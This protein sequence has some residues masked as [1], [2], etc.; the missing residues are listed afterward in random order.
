MTDRRDRHAFYATRNR[1][2]RQMEKDVE[3][4][5]SEVR[6]GAKACAIA[7]TR[8][9]G[10][11]EITWSGTPTIGLSK[12]LDA[13]IHDVRLNMAESDLQGEAVIV[14]DAKVHYGRP[15]FRGTD[16][17]V[18]TLFVNLCDDGYMN[19]AQI[20]EAYPALNMEDVKLA[21]SQA[22]RLLS[23]CSPDVTEDRE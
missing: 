6:H 3:C 13:L 16:V 10:V 21:L 22:C 11:T 17:P 2:R 7:C 9:D 19:L 12:S 15:I 20:C 23:L 4:L 8:A 14:R 1:S 5:A 18:D